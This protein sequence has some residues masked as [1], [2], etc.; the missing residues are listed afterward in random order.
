MKYINHFSPTAVIC[1]DHWVW[2]FGIPTECAAKLT[3][4]FQV[5]IS[6]SHVPSYE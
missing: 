1:C 2:H 3:T 4:L 5:H 6:G